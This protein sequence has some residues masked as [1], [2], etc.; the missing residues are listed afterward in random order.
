MTFQSQNLKKVSHVFEQIYLKE[1]LF[2]KKRVFIFVS[3]NWQVFLT[4]KFQMTLILGSKKY[5]LLKK[6]RRTL[7]NI[8]FIWRFL[9]KYPAHDV[10]GSYFEKS[11]EKKSR[12]YNFS[13]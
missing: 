4:N 8:L 2:I 13:S 1:A 11:V 12:L 7:F 9:R 3:E 5:A 6:V 10:Y